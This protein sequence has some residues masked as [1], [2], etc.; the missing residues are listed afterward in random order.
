MKQLTGF[1]SFSIFIQ[2]I[3][4]N[5]CGEKKT[6][7]EPE[8]YTIN[9]DSSLGIGNKFQFIDLAGHILAFNPDSSNRIIIIGKK[10]EIIRSIYRDS[11]SNE[12]PHV[13]TNIAV[14][15][16]AKEIY[17]YSPLQHSIFVY[18]ADGN[19]KTKV[20]IEQVHLGNFSRLKGNFVFWDKKDSMVERHNSKL[21][22]VD[23]AGQYIEGL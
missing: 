5:G 4:L 8:K 15:S 12:T 13:I 7:S 21:Y 22:I 18:D 9:L 23:S 2:L 1:L 11:S 20:F 14:D 6:V 19:Y 17:L 10:G 3:I 16:A